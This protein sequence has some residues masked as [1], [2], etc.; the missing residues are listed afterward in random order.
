[1]TGVVRSNDDVGT[2]GPRGGW[3]HS[4]GQGRAGRL[5]PPRADFQGLLEFFFNGFRSVAV[6]Y[7]AT[8][9]GAQR[10][11]TSGDGGSIRWRGCRT[12]RRGWE[13]RPGSKRRGALN[14]EN[15]S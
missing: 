14:A 15:A 8:R 10:S 12:Y 11:T 7:R 9:A 3:E 6:L 2:L 13:G 1:M 4:A 5:R